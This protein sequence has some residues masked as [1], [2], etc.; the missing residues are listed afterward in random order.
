MIIRHALALGLVAAC[1]LGTLGCKFAKRSPDKYRDDTAALLETR[2]AELKSCYDGV[3]RSDKGAS[4]TV[5]VWFLVQKDTGK[6]MDAKVQDASAPQS[7]Q[8]CVL[9]SLQGLQLDPPDADDGHATFTY[10][11]EIAPQKTAST[12]SGFQ[13]N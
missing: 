11:F 7:V 4:G 12:E 13:T 3:I 2:S 6:I 8:D 9:N 5:T 1:G 10:E